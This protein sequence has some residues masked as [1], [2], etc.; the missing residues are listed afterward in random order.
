MT[1]GTRTELPWTEIAVDV[2]K[3]IERE[4]PDLKYIN[5]NRLAD[6][7][8]DN[9]EAYP[10]LGNL[11]RKTLRCRCTHVMRCGFKWETYSRGNGRG[12]VFVKPD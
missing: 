4:V 12:T 10:L 3:A 9:P 5:I 6:Q 8:Q 11:P 7:I 1:P 2:R